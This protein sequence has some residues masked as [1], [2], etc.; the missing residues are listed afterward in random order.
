M[1]HLYALVDGIM[2]TWPLRH[3]IDSKSTSSHL[4]MCITSVKPFRSSPIK[5]LISY[6]NL[7]M[8]RCYKPHMFSFFY[9]EEKITSC[10]TYETWYLFGTSEGRVFQVPLF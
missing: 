6:N 9:A 8:N 3:L 7:L 2:L 5:S 1:V 4:S 10:V